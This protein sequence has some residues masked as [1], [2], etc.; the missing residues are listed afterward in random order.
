MKKSA[1]PETISGERTVL[2]KQH[3]DFAAPM[4][5]H[6]DR[7]RD[8]LAR[9]L[10]WAQATKTIDDT[11]GFI[12][13][14]E[15]KW[16]AGELFNYG[17]FDKDNDEYLGNIG[18][19]SILWEHDC[20]EIGY[21]I[22]SCHEGKGFMSDAVRALE[23]TCFAAGFHRIEIRCDPRNA[24]SAAVPQRLG[25]RLD[26]TLRSNRLTNG[27]YRDTLVFGKLRA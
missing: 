21:W 23:K 9:F 5:A 26:G 11:R 18:L 14:S 12:K 13:M 1:L 25:Y 8:R 4:F 22:A 7:D 17:V 6:I 15:E 2:R 16:A 20:C 3:P 19:L 10:P 24:R 27:E